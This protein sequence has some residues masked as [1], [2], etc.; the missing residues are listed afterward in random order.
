[1]SLVDVRELETL[2][3]MKLKKAE[4]L[5]PLVAVALG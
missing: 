2:S 5:N 3:E 4:G 1:M